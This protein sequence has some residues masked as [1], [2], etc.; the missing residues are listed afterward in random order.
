MESDATRSKWDARYRD[1]GAVAGSAAQVLQQNRQLLPA[2]GKALDLAAGLGGNA[3]LLAAHGLETHAW[4]ISPVAI[5]KLDEA[6][7]RH[8]LV[9]HTQVRDVVCQPPSANSFDVIV[10]SRFLE[11]ELCPAIIAA[12]KP[13]GLLFYQTYTR[14]KPADVGPNNPRFLLDTGELLQLFAEL[15]KVVYEE[16]EEARLVDRKA[17]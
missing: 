8:G 6:A 13:G 9:L 16:G 17:R 11:R 7:Q 12:L 14:N 15:E 4:D 1:T 3:L 2:Q 5:A 10:V